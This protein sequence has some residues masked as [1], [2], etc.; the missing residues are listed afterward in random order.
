M[1]A[2]FYLSDMINPDLTMIKAD[3]WDQLYELMVTSDWFGDF[4]S[5]IGFVHV[6]KL[7]GVIGG[8]F[9]HEGPKKGVQYDD[10]KNPKPMTP[11]YSFEHLYFVLFKDTSQLLLQNIRVYG[12]VDLSMGKMRDSFVQLLTDLMRMTG[13]YVYENKISLEPAGARYSQEQLY[14]IF[15]TLA[16]VTELEVKNLRLETLPSPDDPKYKLFNPRKELNE[17]T[18]LAVTT[19]IQAGADAVKMTAPDHPQK[20]LRA[21]I[22]KA[23]A[24]L[25]DIERVSGRDEEGRLLI[26]QKTQ[27][28]ELKL[29]LPP[30]IIN[31]PELLLGIIERLDA[32]GRVD[33]WQQRRSARQDDMNRGTLL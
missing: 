10:K 1:M 16:R 7:E 21:P 27:D 31:S 19:T 3:K 30:E 25:G 11:Y 8:Y 4:G 29:E 24:T 13:I 9:A 23:L 12:Y 5:R 15:L 26:R 6:A 22:P 28:L 2:T 18:W 14:T 32:L 20:T 33:S 17:I